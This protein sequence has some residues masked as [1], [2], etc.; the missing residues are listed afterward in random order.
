MINISQELL[1]RE[2]RSDRECR[3]LPGG[4]VVEWSWKRDNGPW[5]AGGAVLVGEAA[6]RVRVLS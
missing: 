3:E 1:L 6:N 2:N 4:R 5:L